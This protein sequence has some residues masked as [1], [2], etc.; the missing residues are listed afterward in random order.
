MIHLDKQLFQSTIPSDKWAMKLVI[1][2]IKSF[3]E[4]LQNKWNWFTNNT[5]QPNTAYY[6]VIVMDSTWTFNKL[7]HELGKYAF[8]LLFKP[9]KIK[10]INE[11]L[12]NNR[13]RPLKHSITVV[14]DTGGTQTIV[15]KQ[16]GFPLFRYQLSNWLEV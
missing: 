6:C 1:L 5:I 14:K 13:F 12:D 3:H 10:K 9:Y 2:Y 4:F 16:K 7:R 11:C 15:Y 8:F